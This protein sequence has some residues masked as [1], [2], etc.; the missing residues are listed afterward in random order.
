[1]GQQVAVLAVDRHERRGADDVVEELQLVGGGVARDV[2]VSDA[3]VDHLRA[4]AEQAVDG[5]VDRRLVARDHRGGQH[6]RVALAQLDLAMLAR[7]HQRQRGVGL[8]LRPGAHDHGA[9]VD[10]GQLH[11]VGVGVGQVPQVPGDRHV[12]DHRA[13]DEAHLA[14]HPDRRVDHLLHA[15]DVAGEGGDDDPPVGVTEDV[16]QRLAD[17]SLAGDVAGLVGVGGVRQQQRDPLVAELGEVRQV[18]GPGVDRRLVELEVTGVQHH[19]VRGVER[20]GHP[21]GDGV[22]HA[23]ELD[24]ERPGL[25]ALARL[26]FAQVRLDVGMLLELGPQQPQSQP[27]RVDGHAGEVA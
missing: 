6:D 7:R 10:G 20:H 14:V 9:S 25:D 11:D 8:T 26:D 17:A 4:L 15:V 22:G 16:A 23:D 27:R 1:M 3:L 13:P 19:P 24:V 5:S 18:G 12:A 21:V 2:D